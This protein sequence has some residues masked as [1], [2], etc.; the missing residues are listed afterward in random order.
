MAN[1]FDPSRVRK[2]GKAT[3]KSAG[4]GLKQISLAADTN[5]KMQDEV[6]GGGKPTTP[7]STLSN[8]AKTHQDE[9]GKI[10]GEVKARMSG[11]ADL[12]GNSSLKGI[13]DPA[14]QALGITRSSSKASQAELGKLLLSSTT[15]K[16]FGYVI[17]RVTDLYVLG[18]KAIAFH[19]GTS[20]KSE[21][22]LI[23]DVA[24][25]HHESAITSVTEADLRAVVARDEIHKVAEAFGVQAKEVKVITSE[26]MLLAFSTL[27][28]NGFM[29]ID[30]NGL[31][32]KFGSSLIKMT[33]D[34]KINLNPLTPDSTAVPKVTDIP[35]ASNVP[36]QETASQYE[37]LNPLPFKFI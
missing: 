31:T 28:T 4:V 29:K 20:L 7:E 8:P 11:L 6:I 9:K 19:S 27:T 35:T 26:E 30:E 34:G 18:A 23:Q 21:A 17:Q 36:Q 1:L 3:K 15:F 2:A 22:P 10:Y 37:G 24:H 32:L 5:A 33:A 25:T 13:I 16:A 14:L 12:L